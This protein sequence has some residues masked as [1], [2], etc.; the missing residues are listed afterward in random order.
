[1]TFLKFEDRKITDCVWFG[2]KLDPCVTK[3]VLYEAV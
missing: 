3:I 1:M 2:F